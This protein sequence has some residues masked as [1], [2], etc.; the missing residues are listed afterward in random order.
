MKILLLSLFVILAGCGAQYPDGNR[1]VMRGYVIAINQCGDMDGN[2]VKCLA[3]IKQPR[4]ITHWPVY[5]TTHAGENVFLH[6]WRNGKI[7][8]CETVARTS[9]KYGWINEKN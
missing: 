8:N 1:F 9:I 6:C 4:R 3:T 2:D 7:L 5:P